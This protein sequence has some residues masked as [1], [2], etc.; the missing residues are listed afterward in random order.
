[1]VTD[2]QVRRLKMLNQKE[3]TKEIAAN[4]AG[5]D[6]KTA[7]KYI[8][9]D[10][11][12]SQ[13]K[14][15][16]MWR[17]R[18]DPFLG[19]W[20]E[21]KTMLEIN[22]GLE[23]KTIFRYL[24]QER[25]VKYQE[26][27]LRTLQRH[28]KQWRATE[29]PAKEV[30]FPQVHYPGQL[31]ASDFTWMN[32]LGITINKVVFNHMVYHFVLTYS[33]WE[34]IT[35]CY[36]ESFE[37]LSTGLQNA[38][39]ELG[40]VT[41][42]HR[43]DR[44]SAAVHNQCQTEKFTQRY[45]DLL[46]HYGITPER[47]NPSS[48]NENGD[49]EQSHHRFKRAVEQALMLRGHKDFNSV[50]D[51]KRFLRGIIEQLNAGRKKRLEEELEVLRRLPMRKM[52]E[53]PSIEKTVTPSSTINVYNN[54]YSVHSRLIGEKVRIKICMDHLEVRCGQQVVE[55]LP[56]LRGQGKH[57]IN[58]RHIID[59]LVRKP[60]AF[61]NYRYKADMFPSS[62]FRI[63]YDALKDH[64]PL[65]ADKEYLHVLKISAK[66]GEALTER[67]IRSILNDNGIPKAEK[68]DQYIKDHLNIT[69]PSEV[70]VAEVDLQDYDTLLEPCPQEQEV[71]HG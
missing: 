65:Q 8:Q 70:K 4:K 58:Y 25:D 3:K 29:G 68:I 48:G 40:G 1:M 9:L 19:D 15:P 14:K 69:P 37:S 66:E 64:A 20:E 10:K 52:D 38:L 23:S 31:S 45:Q 59:W 12:P 62:Y 56:R 30:Y 41:E 44:M 57:D 46:G 33:N 49:V 5:M 13:I 36:S 60:G 71:G 17:T 43:T 18:P 54:I 61:A 35:I 53:R 34:T 63:A 11:L 26:G 6:P 16:H 39:W 22:S 47:T 2:Q 27:Q 50:D 42:R 32:D 67:A 51:Y 55:D 7:R 24:Q 21:I 28:I